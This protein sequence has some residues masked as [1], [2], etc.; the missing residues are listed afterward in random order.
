MILTNHLSIE[1]FQLKLITIDKIGVGL[2]HIFIIKHRFMIRD[3]VHQ[4][5]RKFLHKK[6]HTSLNHTSISI[7]FTCTSTLVSLTKKY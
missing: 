2:R 5:S 6:I 1:I 4:G 3:N 7:Y